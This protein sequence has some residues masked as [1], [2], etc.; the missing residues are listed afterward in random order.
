MRPT[1]G[2]DNDKFMWAI[3]NPLRLRILEYSYRM[4]AH[5][6]L[7]ASGLTEALASDFANLRVGEVAYQLRQLQD[8]ELLPRP[9]W[10]I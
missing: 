3:T 4:P 7:S 1:E 6:D 10:R 8:A 9:V 5:K 2:P